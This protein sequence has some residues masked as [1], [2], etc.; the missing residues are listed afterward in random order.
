[1]KKWDEDGVSVFLAI[2]LFQDSTE[3]AQPRL[4][5]WQ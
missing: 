3:M 4:F 2:L 1:M 5:D